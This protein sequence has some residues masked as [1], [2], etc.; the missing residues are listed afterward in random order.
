MWMEL[1]CSSWRP[2]VENTEIKII[3]GLS[4]PA[5]QLP[6]LKQVAHKTVAVLTMFN[7]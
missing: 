6:M 5:Y 1:Q 4:D 3:T 7:A 2:S